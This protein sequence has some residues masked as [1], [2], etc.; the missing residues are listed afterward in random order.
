M[1]STAIHEPQRQAAVMNRICIIRTFCWQCLDLLYSVVQ[2][3][4]CVIITC[5]RVI[6]TAD[7][8]QTEWHV[9]VV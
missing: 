5:V 1:A 2:S 8:C 9:A 6:V 7:L 4:V 3:G